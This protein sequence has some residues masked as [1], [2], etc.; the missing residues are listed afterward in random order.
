MFWRRGKKAWSGFSRV[1][2]QVNLFS[3]SNELHNLEPQGEQRQNTPE[4]LDLF[5]SLASL[6]ISL[7]WRCTSTKANSTYLVALAA[8]SSGCCDVNLGCWDK[9]LAP[10]FCLKIALSW[11]SLAVTSA[12]SVSDQIVPR[13]AQALG[14]SSVKTRRGALLYCW[15]TELWVFSPVTWISCLSR[16][17]WLVLFI[18][19][20]FSS[21]K[22]KPFQYAYF[23]SLRFRH[24]Y[25]I[26]TLWN[27]CW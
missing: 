21:L 16:W 3:L 5:S 4:T 11:G 10:A 12:A 7:C 26:E 1:P 25:N 6:F 23:F 17:N 22:E 13:W 15:M 27:S 14:G 18:M 9:Q 24:L 2:D 20:N 8:S 19:L